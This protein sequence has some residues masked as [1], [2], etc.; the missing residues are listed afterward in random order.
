PFITA[1]RAG[2]AGK[3]RQ[4]DD[5]DTGTVRLSTCRGEQTRP[6]R[7]YRGPAAGG[8]CRLPGAAF[9]RLDGAAD[10]AL[11]QPAARSDRGPDLRPR[12]AVRLRQAAAAAVVA[13]RDHAPAVRR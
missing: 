4:P 8:V 2:R 6:A 9:D 1:S 10:A 12:V 3:P 5:R 11:R 7:L 13:H